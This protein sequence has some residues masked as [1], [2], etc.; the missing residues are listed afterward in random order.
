MASGKSIASYE[1]NSVSR[2]SQQ[3]AEVIVVGAGAAGMAAALQL[4]RAGHAVLLLDRAPLPRD[5]VCGEGIMPLGIAELERLELPPRSLP[6]EDFIGLEYHSHHQSLRLELPHPLKGR[7]IRRT[8]LLGALQQAL[9]GLPNLRW[10][11]SRVR[12]LIYQGGRVVGVQGTAG[13]FRAPLVLACDGVQSGLARLA[14]IPLSHFGERYAVRQHFA[15]PSR[16]LDARV[17]VGL[18]APWD[19]YVTPVAPNEVLFTTMTDAPGLRAIGKNYAAWL[20]QGPFGQLLNGAAPASPRLGWRQQ[21]FFAGNRFTPGLLIAGDAGG[22]IDPC[23]G[24]GLS[25]ALVSARLAAETARGLLAQSGKE[26]EIHKLYQEDRERLFKHY[27]SFARLFNLLVT[28]AAGSEM[29][30]WSMRHWPHAAQGILGI[31]AA[32]RAWR[33]L[34]LR[35][36]LKPELIP[37]GVWKKGASPPPSPNSH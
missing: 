28:S 10:K 12:S 26:K 16:Q 13:T 30:L 3:D 6:G 33:S 4:G 32:R 8:T 9:H 29:L 36:L 23:L 17:W 37:A 31:I 1:N 18:F 2:S 34:P 21:L 11:R 25:M 5:K 7:G 35:A 22:S 27:R 19:L 14:G 20:R 15:M 24:M